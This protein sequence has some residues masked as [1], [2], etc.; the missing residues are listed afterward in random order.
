[1]SE[2]KARCAEMSASGACGEQQSS[3]RHHYRSADDQVSDDSSNAMHDGG[4]SARK[5]SCRSEVLYVEAKLHD[6]SVLDDVVLAFDAKL[7]GLA[8]FGFGAETDEFVE[9]DGLS[10]D[11]TAFEIAVNHSRSSW[12]LVARVNRPGPCFFRTGREIGA[13]PEEVIHRADKLADPAVGDTE[14]REKLAGLISRQ[15]GQLALDLC[16]DHNRLDLRH[17]PLRAA[18]ILRGRKLANSM[19]MLLSGCEN[20]LSRH[21]R[22]RSSALR[23]AGRSRQKDILSFSLNCAVSAGLPASRWGKIFSQSEFGLGNLVSGASALL[24]ALGA[25]SRRQGRQE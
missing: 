23:S 4:R 16:A 15:F 18:R 11:E 5:V 2:S 12:C 7:A 25:F 14:V 20:S 22:H 19:D 13:K 24:K 21:C 6:V 9:S 17:D 1:M 8:R 3:N 10:R